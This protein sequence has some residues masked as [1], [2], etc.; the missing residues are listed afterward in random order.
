VQQKILGEE[1]ASLVHLGFW[2]CDSSG[3]KFKHL[4]P[5]LI[6]NFLTSLASRFEP[7]NDCFC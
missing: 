4:L 6:L 2:T 7:G 1:Y 3:K 5:I